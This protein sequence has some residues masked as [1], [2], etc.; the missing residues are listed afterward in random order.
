MLT[1]FSI[2]QLMKKNVHVG[3]TCNEWVPTLSKV[4][5]NIR[6]DIHFIDLKQTI[7]LFRRALN[8]LNKVESNNYKVL[9]LEKEINKSVKKLKIFNKDKYIVKNNSIL[10]ECALKYNHYYLSKKLRGGILNNLKYA[11]NNDDNYIRSE[12]NIIPNIFFISN[13]NYYKSIILESSKLNFILIGLLDTNNSN[14]GLTYPIP[15]ND[16]N[17]NSINFFFNLIVNSID[18]S[19]LFFNHNFLVQYRA[20]ITKNYY[21][22]F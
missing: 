3:H 17:Y 2:K 5:F 9:F 8:F 20:N 21:N 22:N 4:L 19:S 18:N 14:V 16:D 12:S 7:F 13:V 11:K 6:D 15:C 1:K 10:R